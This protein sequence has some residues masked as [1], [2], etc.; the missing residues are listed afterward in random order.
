MGKIL[1]SALSLILAI[2]LVWF[3]PFLLD[4]WNTESEDDLL[5]GVDP[6]I[7]NDVRIKIEV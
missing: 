2:S 6:R 3:Y 4:L 5:L 1:Y 7:Q